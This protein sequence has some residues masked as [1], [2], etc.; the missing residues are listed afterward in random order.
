MDLSTTDP[1]NVV[2]DFYIRPVHKDMI[3]GTPWVTQWKVC[4]RL[5]HGAIE[6][7]VQGDDGRVNLAVLRTAITLSRVRRVESTY[8]D[9][10]GDAAPNQHQIG[11]RNGGHMRALIHSGS[12][13]AA[14]LE[15]SLQRVPEEQRK[16]VWLSRSSAM[17][18][19]VT[20][21]QKTGHLLDAQRIA[22][23]LSVVQPQ[24]SFRGTGDPRN[25]KRKLRGQCAS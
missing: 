16:W 3:L 23:N 19:A 21:F 20:S 5:Q 9:K 4:M 6:V 12:T 17:R 25:W 22:L 10:E 1:I 15:D 13:R 18:C 14:V 11:N 8:E 7:C 2:L 24:A